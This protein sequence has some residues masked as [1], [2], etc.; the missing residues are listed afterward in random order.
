MSLTLLGS[1]QVARGT[2]A[3][4]T[5]VTLLLGELC[6]DTT[7]GAVYIGDGST[8]GGIP[9]A[10]A[11]SV[12]T[13]NGIAPV[14]GNVSL[15]SPNIPDAVTALSISTGVVNIDCSL[16][17][18]FTLAISANVTSIT[19]SNLPAAGYA[20]T[21]MIRFTQDATTAYTVAWPASFKWAG[22][23][24]GVIS[25]TLSAVDVLAITTFDQGTSWQSTLAKAFS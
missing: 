17:D 1:I 20:R 24:A 4:R 23:T 12:S 19:F 11:S 15:R 10:G 25:T 21:L 14:S 16:G 7:L 13:V 5:A 8:A 9:V 2:T 22:G 18:Y 3:Q 6:Y